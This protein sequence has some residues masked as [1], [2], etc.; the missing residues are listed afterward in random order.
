MNFKEKIKPFF[1]VEYEDIVS[2][3]LDTGDLYLQ[4]VFS[5]YSYEGSGYEWTG[6][7]E[8]F[9]D[10]KCPGLSDDIN[11]DPEA[12]M[13]CAYSKDQAALR[14]FIIQFREACEDK[15]LMTDLL[16]RAEPD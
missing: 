1:W 4:D 16:S 10:E 6:L 3:C 5:T 15:P 8:V 11:F 9:L 13:F 2:V 12:G 14:D 7:A